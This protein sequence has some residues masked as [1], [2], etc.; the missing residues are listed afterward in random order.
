MSSILDNNHSS[1]SL[2][3][4]AKQL[5]HGVVWCE[6]GDCPCAGDP[7]LECDYFRG[8]LRE[9]QYGDKRIGGYGD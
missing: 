2:C 4:E 3:P 1:M 8:Y 9:V 6:L 5:E 7:D